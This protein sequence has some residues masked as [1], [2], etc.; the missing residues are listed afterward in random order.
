MLN[1]LN[2]TW[3]LFTRERESDKFDFKCEILVNFDNWQNILGNEANWRYL[4]VLR[5]EYVFVCTKR[6]RYWK[7][8]TH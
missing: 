8:Y 3:S 5:I 7:L 6:L 2:F 1:I 4:L